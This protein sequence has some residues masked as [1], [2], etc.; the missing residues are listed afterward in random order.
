V[1]NAHLII[2][3]ESARL[4]YPPSRVWGIPEAPWTWMARMGLQNAR[5]YMLTGVT[6]LAVALVG[7]VFSTLDTENAIVSVAVF[8][9]SPLACNG[10]LTLRCRWM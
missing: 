8:W 5:R 10:R 1:F 4:G 3:A 7:L 9:G 2:A 6:L